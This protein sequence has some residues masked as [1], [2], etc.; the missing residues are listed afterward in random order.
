MILFSIVD[1]DELGSSVS[2][3]SRILNLFFIS[4]FGIEG[5]RFDLN[6]WENSNSNSEVF[7]FHS[8]TL[9]LIE[10]LQILVLL[11]SWII[12]SFFFSFFKQSRHLSLLRRFQMHSNPRTANQIRLFDK[13]QSHLLKIFNFFKLVKL[14]FYLRKEDNTFPLTFTLNLLNTI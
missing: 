11:E 5:L 10:Y 14:L 12:L 3:L 4:V 1:F 2:I 6:W 13:L 7:I 9:L 8:S